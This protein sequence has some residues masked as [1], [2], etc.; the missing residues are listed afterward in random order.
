MLNHGSCATRHSAVCETA[1]SEPPSSNRQGIFFFLCACKDSNLCSMEPRPIL[2][3]K[4]QFRKWNVIADKWLN[5]VSQKKR[6]RSLGKK[7]HLSAEEEQ[8]TKPGTFLKPEKKNSS[9]E[10]FGR[11]PSLRKPRNSKLILKRSYSHPQCSRICS[12]VSKTKNNI[13]TCFWWLGVAYN[14]IRIS[15]EVIFKFAEAIAECIFTPFLQV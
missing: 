15:S 9:V 4:G 1:S 13:W 11:N 6:L 7:Q 3:F 5:K 14:V 10:L 2:I 12:V 8:L